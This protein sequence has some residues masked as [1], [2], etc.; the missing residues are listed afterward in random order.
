MGIA[1]IQLLIEFY[2]ILFVNELST[3]NFGKINKIILLFKQLK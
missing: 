1:F 2:R 3:S